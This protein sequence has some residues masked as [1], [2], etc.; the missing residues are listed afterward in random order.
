MIG[1]P[2]ASVT[3]TVKVTLGVFGVNV[4]EF[5]FVALVMMPPAICHPNV[6]DTLANTEAVCPAAQERL[7]P[8]VKEALRPD[9]LLI[10]ALEKRHGDVPA[11]PHFA[12]VSPSISSLASPALKN[13]K[14]LGGRPA[15]LMLRQ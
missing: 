10:S 7:F 4:T 13:M 2:F 8:S 1:H 5:V 12:S 11:P 14:R 6:A 9:V 15:T 3:V